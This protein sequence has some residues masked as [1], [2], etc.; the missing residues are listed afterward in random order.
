MPHTHPLYNVIAHSRCA[1]SR[2]TRNDARGPRPLGAAL[3]AA[4]RY[5]AA[6]TEGCT[7]TVRPVPSTGP[8]YTLRVSGPNGLGATDSCPDCVAQPWSEVCA[9]WYSRTEQNAGFHNTAWPLTY[10]VVHA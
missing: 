4:G 3:A 5:A 9:A 7:Y 2:P 10:R 1:G 6:S 8:R